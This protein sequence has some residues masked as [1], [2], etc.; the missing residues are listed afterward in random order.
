[1][2]A[3]IAWHSCPAVSLIVQL[4]EWDGKFYGGGQGLNWAVEPKEKIEWEKYRP[5]RAPGDV[6]SDTSLRMP[7]RSYG[8]QLLS[9]V[10][11]RAE[12]GSELERRSEE[13]G[14]A[15]EM[16]ETAHCLW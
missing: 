6:M 2:A 7:A 4:I 3:D 5:T 11:Y 9:A 10:L 13:R 15:L 8:S 14:R 12:Q 16:L 1:M